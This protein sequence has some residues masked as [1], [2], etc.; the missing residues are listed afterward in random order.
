MRRWNFQSLEELTFFFALQMSL[1]IGCP[2]WSF[3]GWVGNF[4]P[5]KTK[6]VDYLREYTRR[7]NTVEGNT[8]FYAIPS[9]QTISGWVGEMPAGFHF[10]PKIPRAIS[11]EGGLSQHIGLAHDFVKVMSGLGT[12]LGPMFLQ[13]PPRFS[14]NLFT[15]LEAFLNHWPGDVRLAV[16]VRNLDW[17][18]SPHNDRL[19]QLLRERG[20]ARVVIDTR[21]IR[22]LTDDSNIQGSAYERLLEARQQ[23]PNLP[24]IPEHTADFIFIRFIGHPRKENNSA[25][26]TE[27][28]AYLAEELKDGG[29]AY[30]FCHSPD[31]MLAPYLCRDLYT[32]VCEKFP[33]PPLPWTETDSNRL[34]QGRLF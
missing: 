29:N 17:F 27:W 18:D 21:P 15:E 20:M 7:L 13:L 23:K 11:H 2:V 9:K 31:N 14:P 16:E 30:V 34:E 19:N 24:V 12:R 32:L 25:F 3:K 1:Y 33:L 22:K 4:Y 28:G 5:Q 8:T 6:P 10:C 26:I